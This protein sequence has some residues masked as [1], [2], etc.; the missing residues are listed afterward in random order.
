MGDLGEKERILV[1]DD[2]EIHLAFV[3]S[4][5]RE[6]YSVSSVTSG[7]A[8]LD[9]LGEGFAPALVILD[10][11]MPKMDGFETFEKARGLE[12]MRDVP[13]IFLT[14]VNAP[15]DIRRALSIGAADYITKPY[16]ME[17]FKN[18]VR[19]AISVYRYKKSARAPA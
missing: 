6:E 10:I 5:L 19:N 3:E 9:L 12:S 2:D 18:R 13:T 1:V 8:A 11:L 7:R 17:N 4:I 14:S 15:E 16:I